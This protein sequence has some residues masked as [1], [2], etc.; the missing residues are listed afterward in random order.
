MFCL[1]GRS[2][3]SQFGTWTLWDS[4]LIYSPERRFPSLKYNIQNLLPIVEYSGL[5]AVSG[6][7]PE[8]SEVRSPQD[9]GPGF[10]VNHSGHLS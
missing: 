8:A 9:W 5:L 6:P 1:R 4:V 2:R 7:N 3:H 10:A